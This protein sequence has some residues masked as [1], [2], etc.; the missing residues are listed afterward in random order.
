MAKTRV[1]VE[2]TVCDVCGQPVRKSTAQALGFGDDKWELDL[3]DADLKRLEK[4]IATWTK[5]ARA[6]TPRRRPNR[7]ARDEWTYL[8]SLGFRRHRGRRSAAEIAALEGR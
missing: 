5:H 6:V 8:E 7:V 4:Q 1:V 3:C 2:T